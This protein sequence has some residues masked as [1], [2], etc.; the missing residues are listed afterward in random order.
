MLCSLMVYICTETLL[1][2]TNW[3]RIL[4]LPYESTNYMSAIENILRE[5]IKLGHLCGL[6]VRVPGYRSRGPGFLRNSG[7]GT[8]STQPHE[9]N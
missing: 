9:Y 6:V 5:V 4:V 3:E 1:I 8:G 2:Q 7:S